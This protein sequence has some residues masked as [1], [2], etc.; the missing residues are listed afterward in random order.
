G[1][2]ATRCG[3]CARSPGC[4]GCSSPGSAAPGS[5]AGETDPM[6]TT[7][8]RGGR[9]R[10]PA[11]PAGTALLHDETTVLWVG[12]DGDALPAVP[13]RGV[14]LAGAWLAPGFVDAHV[15]VT[16]TGL[17]LSGLDLAGTRPPAEAL[18]A[19]TDPARRLRGR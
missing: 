5:T 6:T 8:L 19:V 15:H 7:L 11:H 2:P 16:Q 13:G 10:S 3:C 4:A 1:T 17:A 9:V 14:E 18:D 12:T